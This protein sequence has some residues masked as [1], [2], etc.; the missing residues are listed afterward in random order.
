MNQNEG[1]NAAEVM[2]AWVKGAI[3]QYKAR[4]NQIWHSCQN[5]NPTWNW[6]MHEYRVAPEGKLRP[7]KP[8]EVPLGDRFVSKCGIGKA[9]VIIGVSPDKTSSVVV[10]VESS[11][12]LQYYSVECLM[13]TKELEDG[14]PCGVMVYE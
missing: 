1:V 9:G 5:N 10:E 14:S 4:T 2:L 8:E 6:S 12:R 3:I 13:R 11:N 7:W